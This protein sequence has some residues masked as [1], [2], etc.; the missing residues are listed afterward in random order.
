MIYFFKYCEECDGP[1][2][3]RPWL[4]LKIV[5]TSAS[6]SSSFL[7]KKPTNRSFKSFSKILLDVLKNRCRPKICDIYFQPIQPHL[8]N[9]LKI[10]G[11]SPSSPKA[12]RLYKE[13]TIEINSPWFVGSRKYVLVKLGVLTIRLSSGCISSLYRYWCVIYVWVI[14]CI[15]ISIPFCV[16]L[17]LYVLSYIEIGY[18][19][20]YQYLNRKRSQRNCIPY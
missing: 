6:S 10:C 3:R 2:F 17:L 7:L 18:Q 19:K 16:F 20:L 13:F 12:L 1:R 8:R 15:G 4:N 5:L 11:L 9:C 14:F